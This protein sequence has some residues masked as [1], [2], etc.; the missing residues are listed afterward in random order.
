MIAIGMDDDE[1]PMKAA[2]AALNEAC[3][4]LIELERSRG[5]FC[6]FEEAESGE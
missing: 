2:E 6:G 1:D 4:I 5:Q 3:N